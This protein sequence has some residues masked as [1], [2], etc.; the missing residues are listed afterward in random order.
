MKSETLIV[1]SNERYKMY[2]REMS[3]AV[4]SG[5]ASLKRKP[6]RADNNPTQFT[7]QDMVR[8]TEK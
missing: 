7:N 3:M 8:K 2:E 4:G 1:A 5:R 6:W